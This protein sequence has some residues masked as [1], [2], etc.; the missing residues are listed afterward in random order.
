M[1]FNS[2]IGGIFLFASLNHHIV[3]IVFDLILH[4]HTLDLILPIGNTIPHPFETHST[5]V[6]DDSQS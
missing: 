4:L 2:H 6:D 1:R 3:N 5:R